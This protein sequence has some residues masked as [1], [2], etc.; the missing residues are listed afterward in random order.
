MN[1]HFWIE[2]AVPTFFSVIMYFVFKF[3]LRKLQ[4]RGFKWGLLFSVLSMFLMS[5][6]WMYVSRYTNNLECIAAYGELASDPK[7]CDNPGRGIMLIFQMPLLIL[8]WLLISIFC[9]V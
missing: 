8:T 9:N 4:K 5:L 7:M 2:L 1:L 3:L 6:T